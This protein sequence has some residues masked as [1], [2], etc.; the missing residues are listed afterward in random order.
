MADPSMSGLNIYNLPTSP[1]TWDAL[2]IF[3]ITFCATWTTLILLGMAFLWYNRRMPILRI[4]GLPL[5]FAS[6]IMLHIY[7][8]FG[9]IVYPIGRTVPT[10]AAYDVQYFCMGIW[11]P[12]GIALFQASNTRFLLVAKLQRQYVR[13]PHV[14]IRIKGDDGRGRGSWWIRLKNLEYS[15][16]LLIYIGV[17]MIAQVI[18]T[19]VMWL[20]VRKYHPTFGVPGTEVSGTVQEQIIQLGRGWEWWPTALWQFI[21]TW[22]LAPILVWRSWD[23]RDTLGWRVQTIGCCLSR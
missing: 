22:I 18:L 2:G 3:Y 23:I 9:Q 21:W 1:P 15:N 17:G 5:S 4:R 10:V 8:I 14:P 12:L 6:I 19:V 7:W 13:S 20:L 11:F 16:R